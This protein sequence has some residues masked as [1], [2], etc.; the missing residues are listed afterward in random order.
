VSPPRSTVALDT[1]VVVAALLMWHEHHERAFRALD[2]LINRKRRLLLPLPGLLE[3]YSVMTR[4]PAPHRLNAQ[5]AL[6]LLEGSLLDICDLV[7]L[8][9]SEGWDLLRWLRDSS[10]QGGRAYDGQ[11]M[12]CARKGGATEILTFNGRDFAALDASIE[13]REP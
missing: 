1:N 3:A 2:E 6:A 13:V 7:S 8:D 11:I 5:D 4:L 9:A 10:V 12:A